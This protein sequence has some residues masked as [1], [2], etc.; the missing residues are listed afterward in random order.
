MMLFD[1]LWIRQ[2]LELLKRQ[3][4]VAPEEIVD[5]V[6]TPRHGLA[7]ERTGYPHM[8]KLQGPNIAVLTTPSLWRATRLR[9]S[10]DKLQ[11]SLIR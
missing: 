2:I 5:G 4:L 10:T 7:Q 1:A 9:S 11:A 6:G 3:I 8:R